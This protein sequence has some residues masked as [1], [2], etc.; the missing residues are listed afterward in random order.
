MWPQQR[1]LALITL[2][3]SISIALHRSYGHLRSL[4]RFMRTCRPAVWMTYPTSSVRSQLLIFF[5]SGFENTR[6]KVSTEYHGP[7]GCRDDEIPHI[8]RRP[9]QQFQFHRDV[10]HSLGL[11]PR[12]EPLL[13]LARRELNPHKKGQSAIASAEFCRPEVQGRKTTGS[14]PVSTVPQPRPRTW[15]LRIPTSLF[16]DCAFG[17]VRRQHLDP[18]QLFSSE[19]QR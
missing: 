18:A 12:S 3:R 1:H 4:M 6:I 7:S 9:P 5:L 11:C 13:G 8:S 16:A 19:P 2:T 14:S 10:H 15:K 17:R